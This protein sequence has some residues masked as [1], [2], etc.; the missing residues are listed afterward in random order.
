[1]TA[2][3]HEFVADREHQAG[4][5]DRENQNQRQDVLEKHLH[6]PFAG[7]RHATHRGQQETDQ[8]E[9]GGDIERVKEHQSFHTMNIE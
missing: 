9:R 4:G 1:M 3:G 7:V 6:R 8:H 5:G 2:A